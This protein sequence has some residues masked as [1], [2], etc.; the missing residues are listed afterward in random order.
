MTRRIPDYQVLSFDC[1]GTLIDWETGIWE[2]LQPLLVANGQPDLD[3]SRVLGVFALSESDQEARN[4]TLAYP[5]ILNRVHRDLAAQLG[6]ETNRDLDEAFGSSVPA[7]PAFDDSSL[8]L[9][10]LAKDY[11]MVI[12]S[13]VDRAGFAASQRALGIEF[14]AVYT[15]EDIGS[16]KPNRRNFEYLLEHLDR[17][18]GVGA[19]DLLHVAQSLFHDHIPARGMGLA[20]VWIDRQRLSEGGRWGATAR[21]DELPVPDHRFYSMAEFANEALNSASS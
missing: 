13:N 5:G 18:F 9:A 12:L 10:A 8:A 17:D 3:R 14:D 16:Y 11:R 20:T 21:V 1:Y 6:L 19:D 4:P 7:W 2:A 15:A